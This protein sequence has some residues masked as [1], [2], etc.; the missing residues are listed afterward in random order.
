M[1]DKD[2][3]RAQDAFARAFHAA[4]KE[5]AYALLS[6]IC[7][8]KADRRK[9]AVQNKPL[10]EQVM[11][12]TDRNTTMYSVMRLFYEFSGDGDVARRVDREPAVPVRARALFYLA[13]YYD[14]LGNATLVDT[15]FNQFETLNQRDGIEWKIF[16]MFQSTHGKP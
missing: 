8:L 13:W 9:A 16:Q 6:C 15:C 7:A 10:L 11:R 1:H 4:P 2:W 12:K 5:T 14:I 3:T